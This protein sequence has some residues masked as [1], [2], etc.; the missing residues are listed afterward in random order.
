MNRMIQIARMEFKMTAANKAF[1]IITILGPFF[2]LAMSFLPTLLAKNSATV[3]EGTRIIV[4]GSDDELWSEITS[5][6]IG[7]PPIFMA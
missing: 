4:V 1:I 6:T 7:S 2:I 3:E 5:T